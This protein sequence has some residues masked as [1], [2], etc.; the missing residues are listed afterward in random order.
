MP[1]TVTEL[2]A[3][4]RNRIWMDRH[5]ELWFYNPTKQDWDMLVSR[6]ENNERISRGFVPVSHQIDQAEAAPFTK[7]ATAVYHQDEQ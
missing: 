6:T 3:N 7:V 5:R 2:K 1:K 4:H